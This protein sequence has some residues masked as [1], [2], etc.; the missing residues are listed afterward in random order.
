MNSL[1][2]HT[3]PVPVSH[4]AWAGL[5]GLLLAGLAARLALAYFFP[6]TYHPDEVYQI[7]EQAYSF[8]AP[9]TIVTWDYRDKIRSWL[10][11]ILVATFAYPAETLFE[12]A[13]A[14]KFSSQILFSLISLAGIWAAWS[15]GRLTSENHGW[16]GGLVAAFWFEFVYFAPHALMDVASAHVLLAG[17]AVLM[18][19]NNRRGFFYGGLLLGITF[20]MRIQL[21]PA[22][23]FL[24][25]CFCKLNWREKWVPLI[26]GGLGPL[27]LYGA[28][29]WVMIGTPYLSIYN[30]FVINLIYNKASAYG[31]SPFY[32]Y[33]SYYYFAVFG[34]FF[35]FVI[36]WF[37]TGFRKWFPLIGAGLIIIF[38]HSFVP[39]KEYRF[40]YSA[41]LLLV[42]AATYSSLSMVLDILKQKPRWVMPVLGCL[43]FS[44]S[45]SVMLSREGQT[46]LHSFRPEVESFAWVASRPDICGIGLLGVDWSTVPASVGLHKPI[47]IYLD[48]L[49]SPKNA[50]KLTAS[51]NVLLVSEIIKQEEK[52]AESS[53]II[54]QGFS[55]IA[56]FSAPYQ[57]GLCVWKREGACSPNPEKSLN[58]YLKAHGK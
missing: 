4:K 20:I 42:M 50:T 22:L 24:A 46:M 33:F 57:E 25:L 14:F 13:F 10:W 9:D 39:H 55:Q 26:A 43:W 52:N 45:T 17:V 38:M 40:I 37:F 23:F 3:R 31:V 35:I 15:I 29:D 30:Y 51:Y 28:V 48:G 32:S 41:T 2:N 16:L 47:P 6:R 8:Y 49:E 12:T 54:P 56:C 53:T 5:L 19:A 27:T 21:T 44:I 1:S 36:L 7:L 11:P 18:R 34:N 58:G